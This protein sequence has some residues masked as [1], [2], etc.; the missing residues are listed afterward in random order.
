MYCGRMVLQV[1]LTHGKMSDYFED[2][3]SVT[4]REVNLNFHFLQLNAVVDF[5]VASKDKVG[6]LSH[7]P[8]YSQ[9]KACQFP[10]VTILALTVAMPLLCYHAS[11][12]FSFE[13]AV[14]IPLFFF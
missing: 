4:F 11:H 2:D 8:H 1:E 10:L 9:I 5:L 13:Y 3:R 7:V 14:S 6:V 12:T